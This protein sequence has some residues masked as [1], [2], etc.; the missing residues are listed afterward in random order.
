MVAQ[1]TFNGLQAFFVASTIHAIDFPRPARHWLRGTQNALAAVLL[2]LATALPGLS[3]PA[4]AQTPSMLDEPATQVST[5]GSHSCAL[6]SG[7]GVK[8]WGLNST[9]QL[10]DNSTIQRLTPVDVSGLATGVV[11]ISTG[12]AH[13]CALTTIGAVKCWGSNSAGQLGDST[14]TQRLTPVD[15][16]GLGGGVAAISAHG[17]HTCAVTTAVAMKCW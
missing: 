16:S 15:V 4:A 8:C 10:G 6:T 2:I 12:Q 13:T 14:T 5:N 7:G 11:A 1:S 3:Q 9:G 17:N